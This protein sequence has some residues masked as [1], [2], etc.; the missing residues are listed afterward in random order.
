M[1]PSPDRPIAKPRPDVA[2]L[3][4]ASAEALARG[5]P[6]AAIAYLRRALREPP[7]SGDRP[8]VSRELGRALLLADE[9]EGIEVLRAVRSSF[10]DPLERAAI[11]TEL[12]V[13]LAF[14]RPGREGVDL[15]EESLEEIPDAA[16]GLALLIR[17]HLLIHTLSGLEEVPPPILPEREAWPDGGTQE[18][19][20][21]LRQLSFLY[22]IGLGPVEYGL[23]L[24]TR[25][26]TDL[27]AYAEDVRAGMPAHYVF[28]AQTL[29]DRGDL[30]P[31]PIAVAIEASERRGAIPAVGSGYGA[32]GYCRYF[33]G[34][35]RGAEADLGIALRLMSPASLFVPTRLG[36]AAAMRI[37]MPAASSERRGRC[38]TIW[39]RAAFPAAESPARWASSPAPSCAPRAAATRRRGTTSSPPGSG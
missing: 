36:L 30:I 16:A 29:A 20:F 18:G 22:A 27:E 7:L 11:A 39:G 3:R 9:P 26:G 33:D 25:V 35:L 12:S 32:R 2:Q 19:R 38:S 28:G 10:D 15:L 21:L 6:A 1:Q 23:E 4:S 37:A 14:R 34:D 31:E 24:A 17:G 8:A 13:S 5:A